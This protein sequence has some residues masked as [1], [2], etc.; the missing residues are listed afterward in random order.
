MSEESTLLPLPT[1]IS[2]LATMTATTSPTATET[3]TE[4]TILYIS[5][6][7]SGSVVL[8]ILVTSI[9]LTVVC[10]KRKMKKRPK[11][12]INNPGEL[13]M[14]GNVAYRATTTEDNVIQNREESDNKD[15][16]G[17]GIYE[18][19]YDYATNTANT[20][21]IQVSNNQAYGTVQN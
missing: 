17:S 5:V 15:N 11:T 20:N 19:I 10:L 14:S 12:D 16:D 7:T 21:D 13:E 4:R 1:T 8:L 9:I 2:L 3:T 18:Y 6:G